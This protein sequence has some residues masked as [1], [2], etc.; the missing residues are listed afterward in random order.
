MVTP[1]HGTS[2]ETVQVTVTF[3]VPVDIILNPGP[4]IYSVGGQRSPE[5][6]HLIEQRRLPSL[7]ESDS[8]LLQAVQQL[9]ELTDAVQQSLLHSIIAGPA[10]WQIWRPGT[11]I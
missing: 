1:H 10:T 6:Q 8:E 4:A 9:L 5:I 7:P 11:T 2:R 3:S